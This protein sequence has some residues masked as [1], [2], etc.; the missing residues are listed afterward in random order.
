MLRVRC[1]PV[2]LYLYAGVVLWPHLAIADAVLTVDDR[3][4]NAFI[5]LTDF[6]GT[7][8]G[9]PQT[10]TPPFGQMFALGIGFASGSDAWPLRNRQR[11]N[12]RGGPRLGLRGGRRGR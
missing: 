10:V 8:L 2:L 7:T 1:V 4:I 3:E 11:K 12:L 9:G 5:D 6:G